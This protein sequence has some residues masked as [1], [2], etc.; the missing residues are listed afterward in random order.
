MTWQRGR[1]SV[2]AMLSAGSLDTISGAAATGLPLID[3]ARGL[4]GSARRESTENPEAA[5]VLA[6]DAARKSCA[7]LLAQQ[8]LRTKSTGHHVTTEQVVRAQFGGPFDSFATLRR[9]RVEIEYPRFP[10]DDIDE[11]EVL[12][13]LDKAQRILDS[14][15]QLL[16][17]LSLFRP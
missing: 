4:L 2:Q 6:Y 12:A 17:Q 16:P 8:G 7:A 10:G 9:R 3:S 5:Y 13:A 14:A 1:D 15:I 11:T